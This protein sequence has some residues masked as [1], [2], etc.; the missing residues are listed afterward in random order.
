MRKSEPKMDW[1]FDQLETKYQTLSADL[2]KKDPAFAFSLI[3]NTPELLITLDLFRYNPFAPEAQ[4]F[5][6]G[7]PAMLNLNICCKTNLANGT[8][9]TYYYLV[10]N[11]DEDV[12][13]ILDRVKHAYPG[14]D[15]FLRYPRQFINVQVDDRKVETGEFWCYNETIKAY[16]KKK[17]ISMKR[18]LHAKMVQI[19][20]IP[21][22]AFLVQQAVESQA[23]ATKLSTPLP[24]ALSLAT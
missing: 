16:E 11:H 4:I 19:P 10:P 8:P 7:A 15:I 22:E 12:R 24:Q 17:L 14:E 6:V 1:V 3:Q 21:A 13:H 20:T 23:P 2:L 5:V 18:R 9:F